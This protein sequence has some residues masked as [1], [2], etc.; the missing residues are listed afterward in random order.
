MNKKE[1][2]SYFTVMIFTGNVKRMLINTHRQ[3]R[4]EAHL[5]NKKMRY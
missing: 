5:M 2:G 3:P 1:P 4:I